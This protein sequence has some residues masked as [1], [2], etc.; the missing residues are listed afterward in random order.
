MLTC[1][2]EDDP[3]PLG[4]LLIGM[5]TITKHTIE[6]LCKH[7]RLRPAGN[8]RQKPGCARGLRF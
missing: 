7:R 4:H 1:R 6:Q 2:L 3:F 5:G 8:Q